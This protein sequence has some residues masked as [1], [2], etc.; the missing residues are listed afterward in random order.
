MKTNVL[1]TIGILIIIGLS[2]SCLNQNSQNDY[3]EINEQIKKKK[4]KKDTFIY[5]K[6]L[7]KFAD[8]LNLDRFESEILNFERF[9]AKG[10]FTKNGIVFIGSSSIRKWKTLEND[11]TPLSVIN[12]G[13]GGSTI[14]EV[15]Y[16]F[17]RII[18]PYNPKTI[19]LYAGENDLTSKQ[20]SPHNVLETLK[21]FVNMTNFYLPATN[22]YFISIKPS[23]ARKH[24]WRKME[25]T[26]ML[27]RDYMEAKGK[28]NYI[29]V[30]SSMLKKNGEIRTDIFVADN[31][32]LN[33]N[34]Y[35]IWT[36]IIK[37][38]IK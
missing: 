5:K 20:T 21:I 27:I 26:N 10:N 13:F 3:K 36:K 28:I 25:L 38:K 12:R 8:T 2:I 32:H 18:L 30:S 16:Y 37:P 33:Q 1:F 19:V 4:V 31:L 11:M 34:G 9:D 15:I 17:Q 14:P 29:D 6:D 35:Q 23:I 24:L 22:I 7:S